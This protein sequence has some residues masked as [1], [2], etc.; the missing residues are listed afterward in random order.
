[1]ARWLP[2]V[3]SVPVAVVVSELDSRLKAELLK[4]D[5]EGVLDGPFARVARFGDN[6]VVAAPGGEPQGQALYAGKR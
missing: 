3:Q 5:L 1:M 2:V 6:L 4:D